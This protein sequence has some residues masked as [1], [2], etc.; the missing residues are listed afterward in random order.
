MVAGR[1]RNHGRRREYGRIAERELIQVKQ[2][3]RAF[4]E[5]EYDMFTANRGGNLRR[6]HF[7]LLPAASSG[8]G[9]LRDHGA[10]WAVQPYLDRPAGGIAGGADMELRCS[11]V[12]AKVY[13]IVHSIRLIRSKH[14]C[15]VRL[16]PALLRAE[17]RTTRIAFGLQLAVSI[18]GLAFNSRKAEPVEVTRKIAAVRAMEHQVD[19]VDASRCRVIDRGHHIDPCRPVANSGNRKGADGWPVQA[20]QLHLDRS[21]T[22]PARDMRRDSGRTAAEIDALIMNVRAIRDSLQEA[23]LAV[24]AYPGAGVEFAGLPFGIGIGSRRICLR[25]PKPVQVK[26][27]VVIRL[28]KS[29]VDI[30]LSGYR[31]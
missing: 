25:K 30:M 21:A 26:Q 8:D 2:P 29:E 3:I 13:V 24:S 4:E 11:A 1:F 17:T 6:E 14:P 23:M 7:K 18:L 28:E 19:V 12:F 9:R 20:I 31:H 27:I 15:K 5:E 22:V 16:S 10:A